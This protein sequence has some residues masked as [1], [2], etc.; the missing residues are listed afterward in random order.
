MK[1]GDR[2][3]IATLQAIIL[4]AGKSTPFNTEKTKLLEKICGQPLVLYATKLLES[5]HL[6][7]TLVVGYQKELIK[8]LVIK[9]HGPAINFVE[10]NEQRGTGHAIL[11]ARSQWEKEHILIINGDMPLVTS[12]IIEA[13]FKKHCDTSATISFVTAHHSDPSGTYSRV[14]HSN[15]SMEVIENSHFKGD[16][17]EHCCINAGIYIVTKSFL[18]M[19]T[20]VLDSASTYKEFYFTDFINLASSKGYPISTITAPFDRIRG[21]NTFQELWSTE[22]IKRSE[23]IKHWMDLGVR[24]S[25]PQNVHIDLDTYIG[26]GT[27][28]GCGV[29]LF[30]GTSIGSN[31]TIGAFSMLDN[32]YVAENVTVHSHSVIKNSIIEEGAHVG[33]FAH[34]TDHSTLKKDTIIGN[35]VEVK[36]TIIGEKTKAKHLAYIGDAHIG[37]QVNIGG[38]TIICNHNGIKKNKTVIE[39]YAYIGSN[40]TLI[41]PLVI[42]EGAFTAA[43][44]T[45]TDHVPAHAL[46]IGRARQINKADYARKLL[47]QTGDKSNSPDNSTTDNGSSN[48]VSFVGAIKTNN[49]VESSNLSSL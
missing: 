36:R 31:S 12:E 25:A 18:E 26:A 47:K 39:N 17:T 13:L 2:Y 41:A 34:I 21:I 49:D 7:T 16:T 3:M 27:Y 32:T 28:I 43:G 22:Q 35:F 11:C 29:H 38:G 24:F 20:D 9:H 8:E 5:M 45:I 46:A 30:N 4:A 44:S 42:H 40:S 19:Y 6:P 15:N 37:A 1:K 14:V 10:Q 48:G 23:L 33:P